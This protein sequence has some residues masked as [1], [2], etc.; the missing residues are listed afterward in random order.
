VYDDHRRAAIEVSP[1]ETRLARDGPT[2][3]DPIIN[4][5]MTSSPASN[6]GQMRR[7]RTFHGST[8][9]SITEPGASNNKAQRFTR[10]KDMDDLT[11]VTTPGIVT[12]TV[13]EKSERDIWDIPSSDLSVAS[14][15]SKFVSRNASKSGILKEGKTYGKGRRARSM[16]PPRM[17]LWGNSNDLSPDLTTHKKGFQHEEPEVA[18]AGSQS[19]KPSRTMSQSS[20]LGMSLDQ[21]PQHSEVSHLF[22][23]ISVLGLIAVC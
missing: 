17:D 18:L 7:S 21:G 5:R 8:F 11:Q 15:P 23:N 22:A 2:F 13:Q 10:T 1:E 12:T 14:P 16:A 3:D 19:L 4:Q 9:T 6:N 20:V